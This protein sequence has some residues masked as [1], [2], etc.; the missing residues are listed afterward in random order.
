MNETRF[1]NKLSSTGPVFKPLYK[2][3]EEHVKQ[4][5]VEQRWKPGDMLPNE[6]QLAAELNVSQ[7]TMRKAL[8]SLT[9]TKV[10]MRKQGVGTFVSEHTAQNGLF[11]FFPIIAD[12]KNPELPKAEL[13][14]IDTQV[15]DATVC[16]ALELSNKD[17]V[18]VMRRR[19][20][21]NDEYCIAETIYLPYAYFKA[22]VDMT[23]IPHTLYHFYQT[24]FNLTVHSTKDAIKADIANRNDAEL[25][26]IKAGEPILSVQRT[27]HSLNGK[28]MEFRISRCRSDNYHYLVTLN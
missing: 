8:N 17:Q 19:R 11:R 13:L 25:L 14:S 9:D 21:L 26:S 1:D 23:D 6:F 4:L 5:I 16:S 24:H 27:A 3:V 2:Q 7:G 10:L 28:A 15:P 12:G 18:I 20:L 22:L